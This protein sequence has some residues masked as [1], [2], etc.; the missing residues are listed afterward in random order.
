M[1]KICRCHKIVSG[2]KHLRSR[3]SWTTA[4]NM[5]HK[6][7]SSCI[8]NHLCSFNKCHPVGLPETLASRAL[9][10]A[11]RNKSTKKTHYEV[12]GL[13]QNATSKDIRTA[14]LEKSKECH[15]DLNK[16]NPE[17]HKQFIQV[18]EAYSVL[19]RPQSRQ[20]YDIA[21][22][23]RLSSS[24]SSWTAQQN[25]NYYHHPRNFAE[26][27]WLRNAGLKEEYFRQQT[28]HPSSSR[29]ISNIHIV[30]SCVVFMMAGLI[31]HIFAVKRSTE[32]H[33]QNLNDRD[34]RTHELWM[35]AK[36]AAKKFTPSE[37]GQ[38]LL[39]NQE[40]QNKPKR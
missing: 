3:L 9:Y 14:F 1:Y 6:N 24:N 11:S 7:L 17:N 27:D 23:H 30:A 34:L 19:S 8:K 36:N 38:Q 35:K 29:R 28:Y 2:H 37:L 21:L 20:H 25:Q 12:L 5:S 40:K 15:P 32:K 16:L 33:I 18:N 4:L 13:G 22:D 31:F 26:E 39:E 10:F